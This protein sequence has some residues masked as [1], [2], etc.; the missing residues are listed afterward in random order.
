MGKVL[1]SFFMY[2][3]CFMMVGGIA[4]MMLLPNTMGKTELP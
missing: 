4:L 3:V 2:L 1:K